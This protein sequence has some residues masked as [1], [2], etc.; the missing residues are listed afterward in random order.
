MGAHTG[1]YGLSMAAETNQNFSV[2]LD[3]RVALVTGG[4]AGVGRAVALALAAAGA[5]VFVNDLNPGRAD[6]VAE[7]IVALGGRAAGWQADVANRFQ[8]GSMI[9]AA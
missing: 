4:G 9:E 6:T 1:V 2:R 3:D 5:A 8:V 7:E